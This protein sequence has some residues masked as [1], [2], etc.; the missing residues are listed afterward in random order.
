M[1]M[2]R[3]AL[4]TLI[5]DRREGTVTGPGGKVR[6]EPRVMEVLAVLASQSGQVVSRAELLDAVWPGAVVTEYTLSRCI[7][8]LRE[9]LR[10]VGADPGATDYDPI[11]TLSKRGYRLLVKTENSTPDFQ[12]VDSRLLIVLQRKY[13]MY[14]ALGL[15]IAAIFGLYLLLS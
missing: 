8:Q 11:E 7:Y 14:V 15:F 1:D 5:I 9:R 4:P 12:V 6:L 10:K 3:Q 2:D 13:V